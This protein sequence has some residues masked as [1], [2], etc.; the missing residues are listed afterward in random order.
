MRA[1]AVRDSEVQLRALTLEEQ[2]YALQEE[3]PS[4]FN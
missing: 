1:A 4:S 2:K 3:G